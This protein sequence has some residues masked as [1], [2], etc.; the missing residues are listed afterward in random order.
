MTTVP[1][2]SDAEPERLGLTREF[3]DELRR[4]AETAP[5]KKLTEELLRLA[6]DQQ[7]E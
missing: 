7:N 3:A 6:E 5:T 2:P 4:L 1:L